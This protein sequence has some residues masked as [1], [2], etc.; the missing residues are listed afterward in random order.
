MWKVANLVPVFKSGDKKMVENY[1]GISLLCIISKVL[2]KCVFSCVFPYFQPKLYHLQ[3]GVVKGRSCVTS[4]LRCTFAF[5]KALDEK[6]QLDA[7][8]LDYSKAFDSV[9][10]N[11]L[12][13]ELYGV[14]IRG[15][16][17][18]WFRSYRTDRLHMTVIDGC[19]SSLLPI[20]SVCLRG[21]SWD[22]CCL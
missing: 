4:L 19:V 16:L 2:E 7:V 21:P 6:K 15:N 10:C 1:R 18:S 17:L 22:P 13:R 3:D 8:F 11:C 20:S 12:L 5:A 14:G 9:S